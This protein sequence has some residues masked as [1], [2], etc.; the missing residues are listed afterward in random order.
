MKPPNAALEVLTMR[1]AHA[2]EKLNLAVEATL[3]AMED[4]IRASN[5]AQAAIKKLD[6]LAKGIK[7]LEQTDPIRG[8]TSQN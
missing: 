2:R 7:I 4:F 6:E 5:E 1:E 3:T 8:G